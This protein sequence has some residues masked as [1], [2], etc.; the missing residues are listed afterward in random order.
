MNDKV[1]PLQQNECAAWRNARFLDFLANGSNE[2]GKDIGVSYPEQRGEASLYGLSRRLVSVEGMGPKENLEEAE[3][4][5]LVEG[6]G[7][8]KTDG[9]A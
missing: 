4:G 9:S 5:W 8:G 3:G 7:E 2:R 6:C 1:A